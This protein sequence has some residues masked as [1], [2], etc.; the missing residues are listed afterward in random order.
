M[1]PVTISIASRE[2]APV[3]LNLQ[4]LAYESEA[5]LYNDWTLPPLTQTLDALIAECAI[6]TVL[7]ATIGPDIVGSVR[8]KRS[9]DTCEIGR[10]IVHPQLQRRGI[11]SRLLEQAEL[12]FADVRRFEL[13]TG[14]RSE[15]NI[16]LYQRH[17]YAVFKTLRL[18]D[19]VTLVF[20]EKSNAPV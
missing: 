8:A 2:D 7:K 19:T 12:H 17:G 20:M 11:G 9:G 10:L 6:S 4:K 13:F 5:R 3:I 14:S 16:R 18:S 15:A 1:T